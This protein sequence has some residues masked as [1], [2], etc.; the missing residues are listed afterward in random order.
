LRNSS[1]F[2]GVRL[3]AST[4]WRIRR[5]AST[6][7]RHETSVKKSLSSTSSSGAAPR[8]LPAT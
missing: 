4:S 7:V 2:S 6:S 8:R 3:A 5:A 1:S